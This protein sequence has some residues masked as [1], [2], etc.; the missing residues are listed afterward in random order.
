MT[1][2]QAAWQ[3]TWK[4]AS[5]IYGVTKKAKSARNFGLKG[6]IQ[7]TAGNPER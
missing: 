1:T 7:Y 6:Q 4:L 5:E 2:A 3:L